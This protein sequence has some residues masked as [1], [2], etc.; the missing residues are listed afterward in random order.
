MRKYVAV[1]VLVLV[2]VAVGSGVA[3]AAPDLQGGRMVVHY[4]GFGESLYGIAAQYGVSAEA[5]MRYNSIINPDLIFAGQ[6][7]VIP[8][9]GYGYGPSRGPAGGC[10]N[11]H[12]VQAGETLT[13]IAYQY[14][15]SLEALLACNDLYNE[16]LVYI[17]Q[18]ICVPGYGGGYA[19]AGSYYHR[20]AGGETLSSIAQRYGVDYWGV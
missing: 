15:V 4:V 19:P 11:Y 2:L 1:I 14:G 13:S 16:D 9:A 6:P 10:A 8:V 5:I 17:G 20:V 3:G 7:L 18:R 12:I